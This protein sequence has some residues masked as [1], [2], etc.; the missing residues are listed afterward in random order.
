MAPLRDLYLEFKQVTV[1]HR[2]RLSQMLKMAE[3]KIM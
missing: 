1:H 2:N 3:S